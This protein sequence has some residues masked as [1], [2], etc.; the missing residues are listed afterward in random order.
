M[1]SSPVLPCSLCLHRKL[2]AELG[3]SKACAHQIIGPHSGDSEPQFPL[4]LFCLVVKY[5]LLAALE[6]TEMYLPLLP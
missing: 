6:L 3:H 2:K 4:F 1:A 5:D